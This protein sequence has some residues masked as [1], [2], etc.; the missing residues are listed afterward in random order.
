[1]KTFLLLFCLISST[2]SAQTYFS[3]PPVQLPT[4]T[5]PSATDVMTNYN[6][7][8]SDGNAAYNLFQTQINAL[9]GGGTAIP[10]HAVAAFN[11]SSC[12]TGWTTFAGLSGAFP[13]IGSS[14]GVT[15]TSSFL[16]HT[17]TVSGTYVNSFTG[18]QT[19]FFF[20]A[21]PVNPI[22]PNND[23][24]VGAPITG[25]VSSETRPKNVAQLYCE[26]S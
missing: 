18:Q 21:G 23:M 4:G 5:V 6:R 7:I 3:A 11:L 14:S 17:H 25:N 2:A 8:I 26:K 16:N 13:K 12:P 10:S 19:T 1:M 24:S 22:H 15:Q 9:S 20:N